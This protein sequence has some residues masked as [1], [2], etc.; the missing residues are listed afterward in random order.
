M[1][2]PDYSTLRFEIWDGISN[3]H[4]TDDTVITA[5]ELKESFDDNI[6]V[7]SIVEGKV[8]YIESYDEF[9]ETSKNDGIYIPDIITNEYPEEA[10][11]I[12]NNDTGNSN[13]SVIRLPI[14]K[15]GFIHFE[16]V[17]GEIVL[18]IKEI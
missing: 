13:P 12:A 5:E 2:E 4:R 15:A 14:G 7:L 17:N 11:R 10:I 6:V 18:E 8:D 1:Y 3:V 9:I 16:I